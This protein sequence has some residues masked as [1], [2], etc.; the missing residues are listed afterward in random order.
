MD[1]S[2]R[3]YRDISQLFRSVLVS[4]STLLFAMA[5]AMATVTA[6]VRVKARYVS[7]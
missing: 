7:S 6:T 4:V 1:P 5:M 3:A 2:R